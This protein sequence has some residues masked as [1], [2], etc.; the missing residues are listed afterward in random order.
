MLDIARH[1]QTPA[2]VMSLIDQV[3]GVQGQHAAS[4]RE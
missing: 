3:I 1:F 4:A 2:A